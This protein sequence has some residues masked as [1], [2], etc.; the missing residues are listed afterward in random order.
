MDI[1]L[2]LI[3]LIGLFAPEG[4][5]QVNSSNFVNDLAYAHDGSLLT[6]V[7]DSGLWLYEIETENLFELTEDEMY[8]AAE[9][10]IGDD[11]LYV[12]KSDGYIE[13]WNVNDRELETSWE[14]VTD[15]EFTSLGGS[16]PSPIKIN[17]LL[18]SSNGEYLL[19]YALTHSNIKLWNM[20]NLS[21]AILLEDPPKRG[22]ITSG[23]IVFDTENNRLI[24]S[25]LA[26]Q[27][28]DTWDLETG[29]HQASI[30][31][32]CVTAIA[33]NPET[34]HF[35][36][37]DQTGYLTYF[38]LDTLERDYSIEPIH[39][40]SPSGILQIVSMDGNVILAGFDVTLSID[41]DLNPINLY[42]YADIGYDISFIQVI[43]SDSGVWVAVVKTMHNEQDIM[44]S[45]SDPLEIVTNGSTPN[46]IYITGFNE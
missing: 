7:T 18:I 44:L 25:S 35:L 37:A 39:F 22:S 43:D 23:G 6:I 11:L 36:V 9:F 10:G 12:A 32:Y 16:T 33:I 5:A 2:L 17:D 24:I 29:E 15:D 21:Q 8:V 28:I 45:L 26:T 40:M 34:N 42:G 20:Q 38:H 1:L 30:V 19:V 27:M 46:H 3:A 31:N 13:I 41:T 14:A 4:D